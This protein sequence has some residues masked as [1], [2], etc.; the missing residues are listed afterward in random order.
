[1]HCGL[2]VQRGRSLVGVGGG[3]G[4]GGGGRAVFERAG[5]RI[6]NPETKPRSSGF[7]FCYINVGFQLTAKSTFFHEKTV[8]L[9]IKLKGLVLTV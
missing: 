8:I 4:G 5:L 1:M 7:G 9:R 3:G 2:G 6:G